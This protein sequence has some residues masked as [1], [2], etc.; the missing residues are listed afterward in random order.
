MP[1]GGSLLT[2]GPRNKDTIVAMS[3]P[4]TQIL[5]PKTIPM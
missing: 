2:S 3:I 5:V 1:I 4:S